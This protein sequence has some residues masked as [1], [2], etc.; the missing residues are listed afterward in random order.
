MQLRNNSYST[1]YLAAKKSLLEQYE[2]RFSRRENISRFVLT[3]LFIYKEIYMLHSTNTT[4]WLIH[5]FLYSI[6]L[7]YYTIFYKK[8]EFFLLIFFLF[9]RFF[10]DKKFEN[11]DSWPESLR[12]YVRKFGSS[13][14][15]YVR[16]SLRR[17]FLRASIGKRRYGNDKVLHLLAPHSK[18]GIILENSCGDNGRVSFLGEQFLWPRICA[19]FFAP[20]VL[21]RSAHVFRFTP[22]KTCSTNPLNSKEE[23]R[24]FLLKLFPYLVREGKN[25]GCV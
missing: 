15:T 22:R 11:R 23:W 16:R 18:S 12:R 21:P 24:G 13:N 25:C 8:R 1:Y 4:D 5:W 2:L 7:L 20:T 9:S 6:Y 17:L 3:H 14:S 19:I 10:S